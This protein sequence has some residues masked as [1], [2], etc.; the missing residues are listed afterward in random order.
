MYGVVSFYLEYSELQFFTNTQ[1]NSYHQ[2]RRNKTLQEF[3]IFLS[4]KWV[5][6]NT[7][8]VSISKCENKALEKVFTLIFF[9]VKRLPP[10]PPHPPLQS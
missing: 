7:M 9:K 2:F 6:Y 4:T 5:M 8:N 10:P 3:H 1:R